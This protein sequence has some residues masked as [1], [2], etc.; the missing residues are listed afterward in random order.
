L[1]CIWCAEIKEYEERLDSFEQAEQSRKEHQAERDEWMEEKL[2]ET[3]E[4]IKSKMDNLIIK[5]YGVNQKMPSL[6]TKELED[7]FQSIVGKKKDDEEG[8]QQQSLREPKD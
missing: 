4:K 2:N 6:P 7:T 3:V 8:G 5:V 1:Y